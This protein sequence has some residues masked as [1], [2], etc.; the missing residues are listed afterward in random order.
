VILPI[1]CYL[2][3]LKFKKSNNHSSLVLLPFEFQSSFQK[4]LM[5]QKEKKKKQQNVSN[6]EQ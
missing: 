1:D 2:F 3:K 4:F 5:G 6:K